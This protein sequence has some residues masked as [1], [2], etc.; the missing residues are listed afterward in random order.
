MRSY[1]WSYNFYDLTTI[2]N[3]LMRW[4]GWRSWQSLYSFNTKNRNASIGIFFI[5]KEQPKTDL[6]ISTRNNPL[7]LS[8]KHKQKA[9]RQRVKEGLVE[10]QNWKNGCNTQQWVQD[11]LSGLR[12][13][14]CRRQGHEG[15]CHQCHQNWVSPFWLCW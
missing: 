15:P 1:L 9:E 8:C 7:S 12:C 4:S 3:F 10:S 13:L 11:A 6:V 2:L 14:A 5:S